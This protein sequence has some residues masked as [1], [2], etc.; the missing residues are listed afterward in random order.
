MQEE[1][2]PRREFQHT[3]KL[4]STHR[5]IR[6]WSC[7]RSR[8]SGSLRPTAL[9]SAPR[10]TCRKGTDRSQRCTRWRRPEGPAVPPGGVDGPVHRDRPLAYWTGHG[11]AVVVGDQRGTGRSEGPFEL[12]GLAE[13]RDFYDTIEWIASRP[14]PTG[15]VSMIGRAPT[16]ST[17]GWPPRSARR[18]SPAR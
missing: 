18:T 9:E 5:E 11:Y 15:K 8:T 12:F 4:V 2:S 17:S 16:P 14:W 1:A 6:S 13:Q 10:C 7:E 3:L